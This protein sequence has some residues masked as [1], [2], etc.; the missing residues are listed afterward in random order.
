MKTVLR[1]RL[2]SYV[3]SIRRIAWRNVALWKIKYQT[4]TSSSPSNG[5]TLF[6]KFNLKSTWLYCRKVAEG[7]DKTV[8]NKF[9]NRSYSFSF[10]FCWKLNEF[11]Q[12]IKVS[13]STQN[14]FFVLDLIYMSVPI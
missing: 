3:I 14:T 12:A 13:V 9:Q 10:Q 6:I 1:T 8:S 4:G 7:S 2:L 5:C 11:W